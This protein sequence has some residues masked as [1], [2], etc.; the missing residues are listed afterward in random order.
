M[1]PRLIVALALVGVLDMLGSAA[2][3]EVAGSVLVSDS[4]YSELK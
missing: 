4:V 3:A 2:Q 1:K